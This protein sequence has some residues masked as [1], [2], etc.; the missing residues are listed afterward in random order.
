MSH[1]I[2]PAGFRQG[3]KRTGRYSYK[4]WLEA[5]DSV[6]FRKKRFVL[7]VIDKNEGADQLR[8]YRAVDLHLFPIYGL[9][10]VLL[11]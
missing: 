5:C 1:V 4:I 10:M 11:L 3:P 2:K 6:G 9:L 8:G 7:S